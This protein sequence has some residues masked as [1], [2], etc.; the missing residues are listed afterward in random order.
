MIDMFAATLCA[1]TLMAAG[2]MEFITMKKESKTIH[3]LS[4]FGFLML[5]TRIAYII[6]EDDLSRLHILATAS[7]SVIALAR[8]MACAEL[9][10]K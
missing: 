9:L 2:V 5:G 4:S 7:I 10:R 1:F 3:L 8:I 6:H